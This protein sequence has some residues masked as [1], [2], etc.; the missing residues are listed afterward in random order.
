MENL[1]D[2]IT[3]LISTQPTCMSEYQI[4][5]FVIGEKMTNYRILKQLL[6][7]LD[8]RYTNFDTMKLDAEIAD[9]E[10]AE[11]VDLYN[12][13]PDGTQKK[14]Q[15]L[16]IKKKELSILSIQKTFENYTYEIS[17]L[18]KNFK[19]LK[20]SLGDLTKVLE[21]DTG[22]EIYWVNKFIKEAQIDIMVTGRIGKGV[23]DAI[24]TLPEQLQQVIVHTAI[25]QS[26]GSNAYMNAVEHKVS[27]GLLDT[28][29]KLSLGNV[30][31]ARVE[32]KE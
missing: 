23:L 13:M 12:E 15:A 24:M 8:T 6:M 25:Q 14:I 5:H 9:L 32:P 26:V 27:E 3:K 10:L 31:G 19:M 7:E 4:N 21:D 11:M 30:I 2:E 16:N 28:K 29:P 18:E 22:E 17:V 1:K 20:D